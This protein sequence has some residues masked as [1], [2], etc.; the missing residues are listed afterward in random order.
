MS[1]DTT[2]VISGIV[3][4]DEDVMRFDGTLWS[5]EFDGS[6]ADPDWAAADLDAV[7]VPEAEAGMMLSVGLLWLM[8][9]GN[10][11]RPTHRP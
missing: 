9:L 4:D 10:G 6:A 1:F 2:G 7:M 5:L 3:F 8:W 11:A